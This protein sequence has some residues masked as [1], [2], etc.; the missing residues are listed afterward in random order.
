MSVDPS[1]LAAAFVTDHRL[2]TRRLNRLRKAVRRDDLPA[3][4]RIAAELDRL[5]GP[6]IQFEEEVLYPH[7]GRILGEAY[8]VQLYHEHDAGRT[9]LG[10]ITRPGRP[11]AF[12][13]A[14]REELERL[15]DTAVEHAG[16]CAT[17]VSHL[18]EVPP[19]DQAEM[20][21]RLLAARRDPLRWTELP[22][23]G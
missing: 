6:H 23:H 10:R 7:I 14:E 9:A 3:A 5:A 18:S 20:H 13:P 19:Q 1:P 21:S 12:S 22:E 2:I 16:T 4:R 17:L 11:G 8:A 15:L